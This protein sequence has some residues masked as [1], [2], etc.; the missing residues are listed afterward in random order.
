MTMLGL[1]VSLEELKKEILVNAYLLTFHP[2]SVDCVISDA[3]EASFI[4]V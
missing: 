4:D 3:G 2:V 1:A